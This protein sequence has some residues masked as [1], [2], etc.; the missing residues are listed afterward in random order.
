MAFLPC[1][2]AVLLNPASAP[3]AAEPPHV[4]LHPP[5]DK[6]DPPGRDGEV[7]VCGARE[8]AE[9]NR[10]RPIE[11]GRYREDPVRAE[12]KIGDGKLALHNEDKEL[13]G[14]QRSKRAMITFSLPF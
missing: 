11:P 12:M 7:V 3:A 14:G 1:V 9:V 6:C 13:G 8:A 4:Y 10:L 2:M 5:A